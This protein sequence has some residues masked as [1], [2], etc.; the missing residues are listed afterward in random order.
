MIISV[1]KNKITI[2]KGHTANQG[3]YNIRTC[4]FIFSGDYTDDLSKVAVFSK[5]GEAYKV[6]IVNNQCIIPIEVLEEKG[7]IT[8]GVYAYSVTEEGGEEVLEKRFSPAPAQIFMDYGSYIED[9]ENASHPTPTEIEQ[10]NARISAVEIDAQQVET[11]TQNIA[12]LQEE[13]ADKDEIPTKTSD[14]TN[15]S[16]FITKNANDLTNYYKKNETYSQQEIDT[17]ISSIY[18]YKGTVATYQDLPST[19]LTIGDVYNVESDGSN[20]AWTGTIWDKLGGE[21]DLSDYYTKSQ[22][23]TTLADYVK[24]TDYAASGK[25]GVVKY[26]YGFQVTSTGSPYAT[27]FSYANYQSAL[28]SNF[29]G[30]GTLENVI[31]GKELVNKT[32][33][34]N[35]VGDIESILEE[36]DIGGGV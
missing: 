36:L 12:T 10:L 1:T 15:D 2:D 9:A 18:R 4:N 30:K 34:D 23:D 7:T 5:D 19:D 20:Y 16:G 25:A 11:N 13:K 31:A 35:I 17:K 6:D 27:E 29:I 3:E 14:L 26:G 8:I 22:V 28:G 21:I 32:Y 24:N 33:V